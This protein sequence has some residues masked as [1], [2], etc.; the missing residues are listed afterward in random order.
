MTV[1]LHDRGRGRR[2][3]FLEPLLL[4]FFSFFFFS[5]CSLFDDGRNDDGRRRR[6]RRRR[7][8]VGL[9]KPRFLQ[10]EDG[11]PRL[12]P[13]ALA[14]LRAVFRR[15]LEAIFVARLRC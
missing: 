11:R 10:V 2:G 15:G 8:A 12:R 6:R 9:A 13:P 7:V 5:C 1:R 4:F 3:S 14:A